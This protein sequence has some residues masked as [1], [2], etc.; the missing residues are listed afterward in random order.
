MLNCNF[1][2]CI[3]Q[4]NSSC[5]LPKVCINNMGF[6]ENAIIIELPEKDLVGYKADLIEK[7]NFYDSI[8]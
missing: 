3:Y 4:R 8:K 1:D 5:T 2:L 6:C 7:M